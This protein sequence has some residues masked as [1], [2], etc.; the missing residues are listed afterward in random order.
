MTNVRDVD[1]LIA[2]SRRLRDELLK[3]AAQL[4]AF[5]RQLV[6]ET[7]E[8]QAKGGVSHDE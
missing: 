1:A 5:A 8:L 7:N 2:E 3:T 4:D 6:R